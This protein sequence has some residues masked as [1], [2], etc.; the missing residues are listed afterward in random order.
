MHLYTEIYAICNRI[1]PAFLISEGPL[2]IQ[3][4]VGKAGIKVNEIACR[5]GGAYED[6]FIPYLTGFDILNA[7]IDRSINKDIDT[8]SLQ[9]ID[10]QK[11]TKQVSVQLL[12][13]ESCTIRSITPIE[14]IL[15]LPFVLSAGYNFSEGD[16]IPETENATAR[17]GHCVIV[18]DI[19]AIE[20]L[21]AIL[22][23]KLEV[24]FRRRR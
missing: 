15:V 2:Y 21:I 23:E 11:T 3:M 4:F 8:L 12:F 9:E 24:N 13:C 5:I 16:I 19:L 18:S 1:I 7:V 6:I 22:Y 20:T 17:F 14:D 10:I